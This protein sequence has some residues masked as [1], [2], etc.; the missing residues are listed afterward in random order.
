ML[1]AK[2]K[3]LDDLKAHSEFFEM[4]LLKADHCPD[5]GTD[6]ELNTLKTLLH[7]EPAKFMFKER[8]N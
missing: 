4:F 7:P 6:Q 2:G 1:C 3:P 8:V 5:G